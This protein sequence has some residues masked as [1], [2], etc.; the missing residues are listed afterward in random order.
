MK[1][2]F[3][4]ALLVCTTA[5]FA[6]VKVETIEY[7]SGDAVCEGYLAYDPAQAGT[8]PGVLIIHDW[9]GN[10]PFSKKKAEDLAAL[11]YVAFAGDIYG[12]GVRPKDAGEAS[13]QAGK[14]KGDRALLRARVNA[15]LDAFKAT[16]KVNADHIAVMGFCFGGTT[17]LE[18]GR[19]GAA[20]KGIVSFHGGL[21]NPTPADAKNIVCKT[22]I[23]HGSDDPFVKPEEVA[24]F[25]KE[26]E[27][28][29]VPYQFV[30][31]PGAVHGFTNP[32]AGS[33]NSKGAA[34][35]EAADKASW[36]AMKEFFAEV[37]K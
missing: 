21:T 32:A 12:K 30:G 35:N 5:V 10:G 2:L 14:F 9:M 13:K 36:T 3:A 27:D 16:N 23:L 7:K 34:Y 31:Y 37:L 22:L 33:D 18:L 29:K 24:A 1:H 26:M 17:A 28:A 25:K 4:V 15:A 6:E 19:S 8:K 11:G 20:I